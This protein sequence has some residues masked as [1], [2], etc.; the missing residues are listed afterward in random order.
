MKKSLLLTICLILLISGCSASTQESV[1]C[2]MVRL[3]AGPGAD[4]NLFMT[5]AEIH[6]QE[7][8]RRQQY[9]EQRPSMDEKIKNYILAGK[10][11]MGMT[12]GQVCASI[13]DPRHI[14]RSVGAWG[15]HEQWVYGSDIR[16]YYYLYFEDGILT[17]WQD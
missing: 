2:G 11:A 6:E 3:M 12:R 10:V 13:G 17:A 15:I 16:R 9:V 1:L 8:Q 7:N 5:S 4:P 14:N